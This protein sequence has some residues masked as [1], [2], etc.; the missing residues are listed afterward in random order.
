M[1]GLLNG[2]ERTI[3]ALRSLLDEAGWNLVAVHLEDPSAVRFQK[4]IAVP[5]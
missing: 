4:A 3:T 2:Q 1:M 5:K